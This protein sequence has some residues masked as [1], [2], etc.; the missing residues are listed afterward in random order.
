M[1][2][3]GIIRLGH[4]CQGKENY[5]VMIVNINIVNDGEEEQYMLFVRLLLTDIIT[6]Y[7]SSFSCES[8]IL[9]VK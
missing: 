8:F 6:F 5:V 9:F 2:L 7:N 4:T 1:R 3:K